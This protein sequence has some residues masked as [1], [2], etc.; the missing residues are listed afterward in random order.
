MATPTFTV[1]REQIRNIYSP[2]AVIKN[3][4]DILHCLSLKPTLEEFTV[5][6]KRR[7]L[8]HTNHLIAKLWTREQE[9]IA[10]VHNIMLYGSLGS[11]VRRAGKLNKHDYTK[12]RLYMFITWAKFDVSDMFVGDK[13]SQEKIEQLFQYVVNKHYKAEAHHP[14][15]EELTGQ[16]CSELDIYEMAA[17]RVSRNF[18]F[19]NGKGNEEQL[20]GHFLPKFTL[21]PVAKKTETYLKFVDELYPLAKRLYVKC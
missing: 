21:P 5:C 6:L 7:P 1:S 12:D 13:N 3:A 2:P 8:S 19:S 18:Q 9:H 4:K 11:R 20:T 14:Q 15:Y 16:S 10:Y 17:D